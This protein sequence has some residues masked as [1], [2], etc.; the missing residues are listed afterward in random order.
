MRVL[1]VV[2]GLWIAGVAAASP[3]PVAQYAP[4]SAD[5]WNQLDHGKVVLRPL[6]SGNPHVR[7]AESVGIIHAPVS[8]MLEVLTDHARCSEFMPHVAKVEV[9]ENS[10]D[11]V[12]ANYTL[13]LPLGKTKRY[14]LEMVVRRGDAEST[15]VWRLIPWPGLDPAET[16]RDTTGFWSLK[17]AQ[18]HPDATLAVYH[19]ASDPG[20][21]PWGFGWIVDFLSTRSVPE[22]M[23]KTR[24]RVEAL[25]QEERRA[26]ASTANP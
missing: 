16:I 2:F 1:M 19:V 7:A 26:T 24:T 21:V 12:I 8:T 18:N 4:L 9:L 25:W 14:R 6:D 13:A 10:G 5:E 20:D 15:L 17:P 3:L 23:D 22:V 11:R